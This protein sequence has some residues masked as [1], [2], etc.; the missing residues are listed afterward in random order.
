L[1]LNFY[2]DDGE[3]SSETRLLNDRETGWVDNHAS[4]WRPVRK[5]PGT[6]RVFATLHDNRGGADWRGFEV[7]LRDR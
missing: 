6:V 7:L 1:W 5:T 3:F 2:A 4:G